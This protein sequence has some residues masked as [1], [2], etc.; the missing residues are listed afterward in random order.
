MNN[1]ERDIERALVGAVKRSGGFCLRWVCPGWVGIPNRIILL[2]GGRV[3]F[4]D[5][6][7]PHNDSEGARAKVWRDRIRS[8]GF[9]VWKIH[10]WKAMQAVERYLDP[11]GQ[12]DGRNK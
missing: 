12:R 10:D 5:T 11:I 6:H 4:A 2:Q 1:R 8:L 9:L 3:I 7:P